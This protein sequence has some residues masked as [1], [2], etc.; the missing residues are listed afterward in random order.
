MPGYGNLEIKDEDPV[1]SR[2]FAGQSWSSRIAERH[3][4]AL[5]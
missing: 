1:V 3:A 2:M 5:L 4:E